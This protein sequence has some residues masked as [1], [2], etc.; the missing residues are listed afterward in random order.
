MSMPFSLELSGE[1]GL[2]GIEKLRAD[3]VA[4][5]EANDAVA[6]GTSA[7]ESADAS[8]IQLLLAAQKSANAEGKV[9]SLTTTADGPLARTLAALGL[10]RA[11]GTSLVP[12]TSSW[13]ITKAAA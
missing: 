10:V 8:A 12:E 11:D 9:L 13:I 7:V 6:I 3:L 1:L 5:L 4:A 2:R